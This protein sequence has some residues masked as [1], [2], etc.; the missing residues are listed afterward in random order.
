VVEPLV[1]SEIVR[2]LHNPTLVADAW[3]NQHP[4]VQMPPMKSSA[5]RTASANCSANGYGVLDLYQE[6]LIDK[7][8]L[9]K[10]KT[11]LAEEL[12]SLEVRLRELSQQNRQTQIHDQIVQNFASFAEKIETSLASP[13]PELQ[14]EVIRLLIDH[15]VVEQ[16]AIVIKHIVPAED[17]CRLTFKQRYT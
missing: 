7:P 16:D 9:E 15:I 10:R 13:S 11:S 14:Q 6:G 3:Q 2:L 8:E 12:H 4:S 1:W 5:Y 17:D